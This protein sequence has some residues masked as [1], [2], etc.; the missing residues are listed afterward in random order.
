A[1]IVFWGAGVWG[2]LTVTPLYFIYNMIGKKD[3]PPITHPGFYFGFAGVAL[4]WQ[5]A[6][7]VIGSN[8]SRFRPLM[9]VAVLEKLAFGIP[10]IVLFLQHRISGRD[11]AL[12]C[13]D[14]LFA[15]LFL[16]AF[17]PVSANSVQATPQ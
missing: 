15:V 17:R 2:V 14:L 12:G 10:C 6:F 1:R 16:F 11:M 3:P 7:F 5:F 9:P 4:A 13:I 8:P